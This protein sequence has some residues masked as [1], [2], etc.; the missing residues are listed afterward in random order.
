M[1]ST[2]SIP[3]RWR[4]APRFSTESWKT[5]TEGKSCWR[6]RASVGFRSIARKRAS[7][8]AC[9]TISRVKAPV[10]GPNST[11]VRAWGTPAWRTISRASEGEEG[12]TAP[13]EPGLRRNSRRKAILVFMGC[14]AHSTLAQDLLEGPRIPDFRS[15]VQ[16]VFSRPD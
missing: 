10:P 14:E 4:I 16:R 7:G 15:A 5:W 9:S 3:S 12:A 2:R 6:I 1:Q 8:L 11:M 13:T